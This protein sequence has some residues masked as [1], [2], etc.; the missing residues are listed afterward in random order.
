MPITKKHIKNPPFRGLGGW[1][2]S[3]FTLLILSTFPVFSQTGESIIDQAAATYQNANG[4]QV[5][6]VMNNTSQQ[7]GYAESFEGTIRMKG[8]KFVLETPDMKVWFDG[9]TMWSYVEQTGEVN[10]TSPS[11]ED[12]QFTNPAILLAG[13]KKEFSAQY[14]GDGTLNGKAIRKVELTPKGKGDINK[15]ELQIEKSTHLPLR[16]AVDA[17]NGMHSVITIT[18]TNTGISLPDSEF[19]FRASHYPDAEIIDLR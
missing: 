18:R 8:E 11:G 9:K 7:S 17:R 3:V 14:K 6:F 13:Y 1:Y 16:I 15:V 5:S 19:T 2:V 10:V 4:I 12:L